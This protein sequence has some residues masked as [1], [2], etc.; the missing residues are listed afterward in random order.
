MALYKATIKRT[1]RL[2]DGSMLEKGMSLQFSHF[3][4]VWDGNG[5]GMQALNDAFLRIYGIDLRAN[6]AL[7]LGFV[8]VKEVK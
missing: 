1:E 7:N 8:E 2:P 3:G 4:M 5:P 6:F